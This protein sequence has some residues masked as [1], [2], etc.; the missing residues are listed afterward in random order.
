VRIPSEAEERGISGIAIAIRN[1][2]LRAVNHYLTSTLLRERN[3][4]LNRFRSRRRPTDR[5]WVTSILFTNSG[6][7]SG[8]EQRGQLDAD[9]HD[10]IRPVNSRKLTHTILLVPKPTLSGSTICLRSDLLDWPS[11]TFLVANQLP[12]RH[13]HPQKQKVPRNKFAKVRS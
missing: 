5:S 10:P 13:N 1:L 9:F 2:A 6:A 11:S 3:C 8:K 4:L 12:P 7:G